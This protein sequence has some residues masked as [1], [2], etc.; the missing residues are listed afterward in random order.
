MTATIHSLAEYRCLRRQRDL[1]GPHDPPRPGDHDQPFEPAIADYLDR[2]SPP[3][4]NYARSSA[5]TI[6]SLV[7]VGDAHTVHP[8]ERR[9]A[10][11]P[12]TRL[13]QNLDNRHAA[14]AVHARP[15]APHSLLSQHHTRFSSVEA[16]DPL[17]PDN[18]S[19]RIS[20]LS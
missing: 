17:P 9:E 3:V 19:L 2:Y 5:I 16:S 15:L 1:L 8:R 11:H 18:S 4:A 12:A 6:A 20:S 13:R 14:H 10:V 7:R